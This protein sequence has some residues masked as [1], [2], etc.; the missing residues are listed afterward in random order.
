MYDVKIIIYT[1]SHPVTNEV[2]Y[3]GK[4]N[5]ALNKRL[6]DHH[7]CKHNK[8]KSNWLKGLRKNGLVAKIEE[9]VV[10][11]QDNWIDEERFYIGY[12]KFLGFRLLNICEGGEG[13]TFTQEVKD[14]ISRS[15]TGKM[16]S[17]ETKERISQLNKLG[18]IGTRGK[19]HSEDHKKYL[20]Q[21]LKG[22]SVSQKTREL[23]AA[24]QVNRR[25]PI[26][27]M[28]I[29]GRIIKEWPSITEASKV[30]TICKG[31]IIKCCKKKLDSEGY[32]IRTAGGFKWNYKI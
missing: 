24:S 7:F 15:N 11:D 2:R 23:I 8:H 26:L 16:R 19:S 28:H 21:K 25:K 31:H 29:D 3:V 10:V 13:V 1:L 18:I 6:S 32:E 20:S 9:L 5:Q 12:F 14:K 4:T 17:R 22:H 30:T 27:Q